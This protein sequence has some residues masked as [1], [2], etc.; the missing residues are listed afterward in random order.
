MSYICSHCGKAH[1]GLP[2]DWG[3]KL[4]DAVHEL[5]WL[6]RYRRCR[7]TSDVCTLD[8]RR[9]FIRCL[10]PVRLLDADDA[11][12]H[13][14]VWAEVDEATHE[15]YLRS[16]EEDI[17]SQARAQGRLANEIPV[18]PDSLGLPLEIEFFA[19]S[20]RPRVWLADALQH[21]LALEQRHGISDKRH[22]DILAELGHF[23]GQP[24]A[25]S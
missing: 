2:T 23:D 20:E 17:S 25:E 5:G 3:F 10:L 12:F 4:P 19:D 18:A 16:W 9:F 14:G 15:L 13:W 21:A 22:H 11:L 8:D 1:E 7:H 24:E 6:G